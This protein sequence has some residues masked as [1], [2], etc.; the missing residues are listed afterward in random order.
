ML[1]DYVDTTSSVFLGLTAGCARCHDHKFDPISQ[2]DYYR[3]RAIFAPAVRVKVALNRLS[4]LGFDVGESVREWKLREIGDQ[5]R[6][7]QARCQDEVRTAKMAALPEEVRTALQLSDNE[8]TQRQRELATDYARASRITDDE[9]RACMNPEET[10]KLH[11][12]EKGLVGMFADYRSKPFACGLA[13][14]WNVSPRTFLPAKGSRPEREVEPGFFSILGGGSVPP[15]AE[16]R[17]ATGPIPLMPTTGRRAA[18]AALSP[19]R[20]TSAPAPASPRIRNCS[21]GSPRSSSRK[22]GRSSTCTG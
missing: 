3:V 6:A 4:S 21:T 16:H 2:E 14:M 13:D 9:V 5:I 12:I 7:I 11:E 20:A 10:K 22:A 15:P 18:L 1:T 19:L 17:T 8:R